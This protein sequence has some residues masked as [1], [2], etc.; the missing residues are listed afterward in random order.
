[1]VFVH[2]YLGIDFAKS[3]VVVAEKK[4]EGKGDQG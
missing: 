4:M 1:M 3:T 2:R